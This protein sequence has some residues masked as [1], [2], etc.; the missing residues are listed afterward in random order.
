VTHL[1]SF[2]GESALSTWGW[3]IA[4]NHLARA[5]RGRREMVTFEILGERLST[6]LGEEPS[7]TPDPEASAM[8]AELRLQ[9]TEA[10]LLSLDRELR[11][12]HVLGGHPRSLGRDLRRNPRDRAG[13]VSEARHAR[14]G[15]P[16][17]Q[18][19]GSAS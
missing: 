9:C 3:G 6:G 18:T 10:M 1:G 7:G 13:D 8:G 16:L 12:A 19:L 15:A 4:A 17:A 2:R 11:I 5:R 14:P